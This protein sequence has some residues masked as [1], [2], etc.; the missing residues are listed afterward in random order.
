MKKVQ[1]LLL[2]LMTL[3]SVNLKAQT[4]EEDL[5]TKELSKDGFTKTKKSISKPQ[6]V[7]GTDANGNWVLTI[8]KKTLTNNAG[9]KAEIE[10]IDFVQGKEASKFVIAE[11]K[12]N[13]YKVEKNAVTKSSAKSGRLQR[14]LPCLT[15]FITGGATGN[16]RTCFNTLQNC[17]RSNET[18]GATLL[19]LGR[20]VLTSHCRECFGS[21]FRL[22]RCIRDNW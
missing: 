11:S 17:F 19:C 4:N 8:Q 12:G 21:M 2:V 18:F 16:C 1:K 14:L 13:V 7:K 5:V 15:N 9:E 6:I 20:G 22:I 3:V 10:V